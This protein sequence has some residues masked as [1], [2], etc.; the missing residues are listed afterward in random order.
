MCRKVMYLASFVV[1][2]NMVGSA[3]GQLGVGNILYEYWDDISGTAVS[4]LTD[5]PRYPDSPDESIWWQTFEGQ[6]GR[7]DNYGIRARGYVSPPVSGDYIFWISGDDECQLWLSIDDDP[8]NI[9][10]V[11]HVTGWTTS[12]EWDKYDEQKSK[13]ITLQAGQKYYIEALMKEGGGGD[14]LAVGWGGPTIGDGPVIIEG[15][16]LS[17]VITSFAEVM[18]AAREPNP[19]DGSIH[20]DT[21]VTVTW[22]A[23]FTAASHDVYFSDNLTDVQARTAEAFRGNQAL[24]NFVVGFPGFPYPDGLVSGTTYYWVIDEIEADGTTL[25]EGNI[26]SFLVPPK[27]AYL[28]DPV[29][30]ADS[31]DPNETLTWQ[32]GFG[33]ILHY[34]YFGDDYDTVSNAA[35]AMPW[36]APT[37]SPGTL[38][39]GKVFY[40]RVDAFHGA[41]TYKGEVWSFSTPGAVGAPI[42]S[43]GAVDVTQTQILTWVASDNAASYQVYFGADK[44]AVRSADTGSPEYKGSNNLGSESYDPGKLEWDSTYYWRV[45]EV[46]AGGTTQKG[47]AWSFTTANFLIVDDFESYNDLDPTDP[48]SNRIFNVWLD[49]FGDATNGALVGNNNPPFTEQAIV[50]GGLQSMPMFYDNA[51]GKSEATLTLTDP[52]DWTEKSVD[53][54]TIWFRG[55]S[56]NTP[57]TLYVTLN[58]NAVVNHDN[59]DAAQITSWTEWNID[60]QAFTDQGVNLANVNTITLGLRSV[61]G[62]TGIMYF[63]DIR[64]YPPAP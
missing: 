34:V 53:T 6:V 28:P 60:L 44:D 29:D 17:P 7:G 49:G 8:A 54:L 1:V 21:W 9:D 10:Q 61:T 62:G 52:R 16:Y 23:G 50:L 47:L 31:V 12:R 63:D 4:N 37:F 59:P 32:P 22:T 25:H 26:W 33:A 58:G 46:E 11:S 27:T 48:A 30:G 45:D 15:K 56:A 24:T 19:A 14:S 2:L 35:G 43:N 20:S 18:Q 39:L 38:E 64:L 36:G 3:R 41:E 5:D 57:E 55:A 13:P 40:W 51:V 42:P